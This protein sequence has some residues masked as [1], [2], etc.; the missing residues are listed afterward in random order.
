MVVKKKKKQ[1]KTCY[2]LGTLKLSKYK[3]L[4]IWEVLR[5][6]RKCDAKI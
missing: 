1:S 2:E 5:D 4:T 6:D 3:N